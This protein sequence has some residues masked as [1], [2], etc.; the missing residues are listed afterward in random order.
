MSQTRHTPRGLVTRAR[1]GLRA[2]LLLAVVVGAWRVVRKPLFLPKP[3]RPDD[4]TF[5]QAQRVRIVRDTWGVPHVFGKS[6]ADAS[7]G[8]AYAHAEDDFPLLQGV[9]AAATGRLSLLVL[10]EEAL[11]NDYY[12]ALVRVREQLAEQYDAL[13]ADYRAVL[14]GY[15]RGLNLY[16]FLHPTEADGRLYPL[17]GRDIAAGFA[18][19]IPLMFDM[20]KVLGAIVSGPP[21]HVGARVLSQRDEEA[22]REDSAFPGS[23]A[24]ALAASRSTD[25][26]ARLNVNSHQPWEGPVAWY[27]A[28]VTSEEGWNM[29]GGLFPGAPI[30]LHGHNDHLG[31]AH[32]VNA[33]DLID[34]Y[35]LTLD[36]T[37][38]GTYELDGAALPLE[39]K[40][41]PIAIDTGFFVFTAHKPV[42]WSKHGPVM[43]TDQGAWAIRYAGIGRAL[44][45]GEQWFRMNKANDL[46]QWKSAMRM[47]AI[48]MFNTVYADRE[49]VYY[50]YN[51]L[52][53]MRHGGYDWR[54]VL[55]GNKSD[56][57]WSEYL[58]FDALPH[59]EDPPSGF[60]QSC[61]STP[62]KTTTG[63]ANPRADAF[64]ADFGI[65]T[66]VTNRTLRS[67]ALFGDGAKVSREDFLRFK[68]DRTYAADA[69]I[70]RQVLEPLRALVPA[71][72]A[73]REA[74][75]LL[76]AWNGACD[77]GSAGA[78]IAILT[79][80]GVD[81]DA[82]GGNAVPRDAAP[83]FRTAVM[84]LTARFGKV[85]VP[86]G[87]VHRLRRGAVD[88]P[89]GG[90]PD[91]LNGVNARSVED[92]LVG[93]QGDSL[94]L[95]VE[96]PPNA[97][98]AARSS[99]IHQFGA[100][101]RPSSPHYADQAPLFVRRE[102]KPT[103]RTPAE[104]GAH[105]ERSYHPGEPG[106]AW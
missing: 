38:P 63:D 68:W 92:R 15:A 33:P 100:S 45:A 22:R 79:W 42:Y 60:V 3:P 8:L 53:P 20:N 25:G 91:V 6:D 32:T 51:A 27:E 17:S 23:N 24:H 84:W 83:A 98:D 76:G 16:A 105:T 88:L 4:A 90:G 86:W 74:L 50:V 39:E 77:E 61:N 102:L 29:S 47:Q 43:K 93:R 78:T 73:E 1:R 72:A 37:K 12:V 19:K 55:P 75:E 62:W 66:N 7:F 99:S 94:V 10:S 58:P 28:H 71:D 44:R 5:E 54:G 103:W 89:L 96:L 80:R 81:P 97:T 59:V 30:V 67:L 13:G 36:P 65:E 95:I 31:W 101:S 26:V 56:A 52:L 85:A 18:H 82:A 57:I 40:Q 11:A 106:G 104:L 87:D 69:A 14:E 34:V 70:R 9:L 48:P 2:L 35:E 46:A 49:T 64:S 41:A 21:K